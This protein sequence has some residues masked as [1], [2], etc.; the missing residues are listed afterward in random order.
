MTQ[1]HLAAQRIRVTGLVQGVGFRPFV[2]RV[3]NENALS[4]WVRNDALGVEI[5]LEGIQGGLE[6]FRHALLS[7]T[8]PLARI[9]D[10]HIASTA[11]TGCTDFI[12]DSSCQGEVHTMI[13]ADTAI[14]PACLAEMCDPTDRRWRHAFITCTHCGPRYTLTRHL[15]YD[16]AQTS[17]A[18]FPQCPTC[19]NEYTNPAHRRFHSETNCCPV[20][21]P[22]LQ[23][24]NAQGDLI[25]EDPIAA[26][27]GLIQTGGIVAIK[28]LGGFHLT[29][30]ARNAQAVATLRQRKARDEKPFALMAV[31]AS[32]VEDFVHTA[33]ASLAVLNARERP[34]VLLPAKAGH[35][36]ALAG[37]APG[38]DSLGIM[39]P[40][41]PVQWLLFHEAAGRPSGLAWT[42]AWQHLLLVMTSANPGGEPLTIANDEAFER[43][44]AI[45]DAFLVHDRDILIRCDDS[46]VR[47]IGST[48]QFVRRARGYTPSPIQLPENGPSVLALGGW[49]KNTICITRDNQAWVSQH[50][51]D[52]D[53]AAS[54]SFLEETVVHLQNLLD[55]EPQAIAHDLHPDFYS[56]RLAQQLARQFE[57]PCF[58]IQHHHAHIAAIAAEHG[59][60]GPLLGLAL[61]GVGL[62]DDGNAWGGELLALQGHT[63][64]RLGHLA[65][66]PLPGGDRAAREPWR[67]AAAALWQIGRGDEIAKRFAALPASTHLGEMLK[68]GLNCPPTTS[69]GRLFDAAAGLLGIRT[70]AAYEGQAAMEL[71]T[72][73]ARH[74][75]C[76]A[77]PGWTINNE[78]LDFSRMLEQLADW[79]GDTAEAAA[80]FHATLVAGIKA[81]VLHATYQRQENTIALGGGCFL[82]AILSRDLTTELSATGLKVLSA[83]AIPPNDGGLS[84]GQAWIALRALHARN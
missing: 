64:Q 69:L 18:S 74:D 22:Q 45:A 33:P 47:P 79:R 3:A 9:D 26:A 65:S 23:L 24:R 84:L 32:S 27:L 29:C 63:F 57:I 78:V 56:T 25:Q 35:A 51:G 75:M 49:L 21:G 36:T 41:T 2:W 59:H 14:C 30:D 62:G 60:T 16:R 15:P 37:I 10:L 4:G 71:E 77:W 61:D 83:Q 55:V 52:L 1:P 12:I 34:I 54:C 70:I 50:I 81:W 8:P 19:L 53:N 39:L 46:V 28:G 67:M 7:Q 6:H 82:N 13:G 68:R 76:E 20:C 80:R 42:E 11:V 72:L 31:N 48:P 73:A 38:L 43:L 40:Y 66:S 5:H 58:G 17:M 44:G